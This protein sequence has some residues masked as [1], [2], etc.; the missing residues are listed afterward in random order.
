MWRIGNYIKQGFLSFVSLENLKG[1]R[2]QLKL[3]VLV[4]CSSFPL[5]LK[6]SQIKAEFSSAISP[7]WDINYRVTTNVRQHA[8]HCIHHRLRI[9]V[10]EERN[11]YVADRQLLPVSLTCQLPKSKG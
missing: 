6:E 5:K 2:S 3:R 8:G 9:C 11:L 1:L 10:F 4:C 7:E